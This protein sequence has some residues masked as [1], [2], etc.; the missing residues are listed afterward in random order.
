[1]AT[2]FAPESAPGTYVYGTKHRSKNLHLVPGPG[3]RND[4]LC[5][6]RLDEVRGAWSSGRESMC[7]KC[8]ARATKPGE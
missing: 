2:V 4:A 7:A 3:F 1:M 6:I 5:G 8:L